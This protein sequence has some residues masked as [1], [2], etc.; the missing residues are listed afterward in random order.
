MRRSPRKRYDEVSE[1]GTKALRDARRGVAGRAPLVQRAQRAWRR[2][3]VRAFQPSVPASECRRPP[4]RTGTG[5]ARCGRSARSCPCRWASRGARGS[6]AR[7]RRGSG[8]PSRPGR[9]AAAVADGLYGGARTAVGPAF[10]RSKVDGPPARL[11]RRRQA[12]ACSARRTVSVA[13][14]GGRRRHRIKS[15]SLPVRSG[16][17]RFKTATSQRI[18]AIYNTAS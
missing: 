16:T 10:R 13:V 2:L 1:A 17:I 12:G 6:D 18:S 4:E 9:T 15:C 8:P 3:V 5:S 14:Y 7:R 11:A